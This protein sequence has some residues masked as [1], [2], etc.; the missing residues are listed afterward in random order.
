MTDPKSPLTLAR[1]AFVEDEDDIA[2]LVRT[3]LGK[4]GFAV[5]RFATGRAFLRFIEKHVPDLVLL[6]LMLPDASGLEIC[7]FLKERE[8]TR[9]VP[10]L[11]A[12]AK[13]EESDKIL[14]L[15]TGADDYIAKPYSLRELAARIRA[16][17]RRSKETLAAGP[18]EVG[19]GLV[20]DPERYEVRLRGRALEL[21]ATEFQIL[22]ILA[23]RPGRVFSRDEILDQVWGHDKIVLDRTVDVHIKNL[24]EKL[25]PAARF[26]KNVRGV[27]YK[28]EP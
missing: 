28:V 8:S 2:E 17:L 27:G 1:I 15:E 18:I 5:E 4:E 16:V 12:T 11:M 23:G 25:G 21:T 13:G 24:R 3:Y 26:I 10:V 14:G 7:R 19:E 20:L 22:R 9:T 6:D